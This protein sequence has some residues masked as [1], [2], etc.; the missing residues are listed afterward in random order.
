MTIPEL[1]QHLQAH[2]PWRSTSELQAATDDYRRILGKHAGPALASAWEQVLG[3]WTGH[4]RPRPGD[5][6]KLLPAREVDGNRPDM[7]E[8]AIR[9]QS[10]KRRLLEDWHLDN[11]DWLANFLRGFAHMERPAPTKANWMVLCQLP[12][13]DREYA[14]WH[15]EAILDAKAWGIAQSV[16]WG[17]PALEL[18]LLEG[19]IHRIAERV[20]SQP[21]HNEWRSRRGAVAA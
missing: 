21:P 17:S 2:F 8:W 7:K 16:A 1:M 4:T 20:K 11:H 10:A 9:A 15:L 6:R 19:D 14:R 12:A 13:T 18:V 5:I 3:E